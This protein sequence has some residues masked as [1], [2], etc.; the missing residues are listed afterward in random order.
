L[1]DGG[2]SDSLGLWSYGNLAGTSAGSAFSGTM[3]WGI[4]MDGLGYEHSQTD[5]LTSIFYNL[6]PL[7]GTDYYQLSFHFWSETE[8][9][10]DGVQVLASSNS[11]DWELLNPVEGYTDNF[12]G[13]LGQQP[14]W[15]GHSGR[16][17]GT[18]FDIT[19]YTGGLFQFKLVFG[20]DGGVQD[21]G[22]FIDGIAFGEGK[23]ATAVP[24]DLV[25]SPVAASL[26]AWPNPF[27]PRVNI[28][29][30]MPAAGR[31]QVAVFDL[32][33]RRVRVLED[34]VVGVSEGILAWDGR[35]DGGRSAASGVYLVQM[36]GTGGAT[37]SQ[38]VV[39][40]K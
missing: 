8:T 20:S 27:N 4:G 22:F 26:S 29:W 36:R 23:N 15:S 13:G 6:V 14:G 38:R 40:A 2:F 9:G 17:Q 11:F 28:A 39:L 10:F 7:A 32:R 16:W 25:P 31:L 37:A 12:L 18:V 24:D 3:G 35:D 5:T 33:G 19:D 34:S 30:K 1:N 21:E